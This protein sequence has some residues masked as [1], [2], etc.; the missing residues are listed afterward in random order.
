MARKKATPSPTPLLQKTAETL[1]LSQLL[2][3]AGMLALVAALL[4]A[5]SSNFD[6]AFDDDVYTKLNKVTNE[7][8]G[9]MGD[10]FGKGSVYGFSDE[11]FGTYRPITLLTF[12]LEKDP[13]QAF[14]PGL[15]HKVNL[16]LYGLCAFV[17]FGTLLQLLPKLPWLISFFI[18][19]LFVVHPV[20]T[21][22]VANVK[23]REEIL[24]LLFGLTS[25]WL[26]LKAAGSKQWLWLIAA[27]FS[28]TLSLLS[29]EST[30]PWVLVFPLVLWL[31][32]DRNWKTILGQSLV[33]LGLAVFFYYLRLFI[34][35]PIPKGS[36]VAD[37]YINNFIM[38]GDTFGER[39]ATAIS[40][41]GKYLSLLFFP[42][43]LR[44]D[45]SYAQVP[46]TTWGDPKVY[47]SLLAYLG[48]GFGSLWLIVKRK[49]WGF[50]MAFYLLTLSTAALT[51][52]M[53]R[54]VSALAERFLFTPSLGFCFAFVLGL[55]GLWKS[56]RPKANALPLYAFLSLICIAGLVKTYQQIPVWQN[57][58][59]LFRYA[60]EV[61]PNSF[62]THL[63][64]A[65][66]LRV[67]GEQTPPQN[68]Q[69]QALFQQSIASYERSLAIY[70]GEG[71]TWYNLG[72]CY[73]STGQLNQAVNAFNK[74]IALQKQLGPSANNLGVIYFQSG[75]FTQAQDYFRQAIEAE[76]NKP[77][78]HVNLGASFENSGDL[79]SA[80]TSYRKALQL[81]PNHQRAQE[82]I[83]R[84][85]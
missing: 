83:A 34:F 33:F 52:L 50:G 16:F 18:C 65:E 38:A 80:L 72:V 58:Q 45:Y 21:E 12:A 22:V 60:A 82:G 61:S 13:Q 24:A 69:R 27:G 68:P 10:I 25:I 46:I 67:G 42:H 64:L 57:N 29:K 78:H 49:Q 62:R 81:Q 51:P 20:H 55:Y 4:Y 32:T 28:Y 6:Y 40:V 39:L 36:G 37:N 1:A 75:N 85:Q 11:N 70:D 63:N 56:V 7:G 19:L 76:P 17:L 66:V 31:F 43:P 2:L 41:I 48:I 79:S 8:L 47:L 77:D 73:Q 84:I 15:S 23:S 5:P 44:P 30:F 54:N 35:D 3:L 71:N 14:D 53:F 59:T 9:R 74:A 26:L